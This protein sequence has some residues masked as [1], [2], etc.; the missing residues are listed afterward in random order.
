MKKEAV[1]M[2]KYKLYTLVALA[3]VTGLATFNSCEKNVYEIGTPTSKLDGINGSW[4]ISG[5]TQI[6]EASPLKDEMD[7]SKFF[8][9]PGE[10]ILSIS[11]NSDELTYSVVPGTGNNPFGDGGDWTFDDPNYPSYV[12]LYPT[13]GDTIQVGLGRT[14]KPT[15]SNL[16]LNQQKLCG[17]A[18][19][20]TYL[21]IFDRK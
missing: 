1:N 19:V 14:I 3:L 12:I 7:L 5:V 18:P 9:K 8:L 2:K 16:Y 21:Y 6:D 11:L 20:T 13:N 10:P 4:N 15:D 17:D